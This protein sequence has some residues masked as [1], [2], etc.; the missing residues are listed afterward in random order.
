MI[1]QNQLASLEVP[2]QVRIHYRARRQCEQAERDYHSQ[3][4]A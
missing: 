4:M 2:P 1:S 3:D